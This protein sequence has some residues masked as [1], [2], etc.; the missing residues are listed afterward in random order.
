MM[1]MIYATILNGN[2]L[3]DGILRAT[4]GTFHA[5]IGRGF[6]GSALR[7][8]ASGV[9]LSSGEGREEGAPLADLTCYM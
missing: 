8:A 6:G 3:N 1:T 7:T 9:D 2:D 5:G 4:G